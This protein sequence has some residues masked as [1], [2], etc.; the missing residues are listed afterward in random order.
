[1]A[2][3]SSSSENEEFATEN[4]ED[5]GVKKR[6]TRSY[7]SMSK[8]QKLQLM[9]YYKIHFDKLE[10]EF[11]GPGSR[12]KRRDIWQEFLTYLEGYVLENLS[13]ALH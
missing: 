3:V 13:F 8:S 1:M 11:A 7:S 5:A 12:G 9:E 10:K 4:G 6:P 2:D